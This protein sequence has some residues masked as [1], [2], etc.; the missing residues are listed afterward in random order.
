MSSSALRAPPPKEDSGN[1]PLRSAQPIPLWRGQG[2][3]F[4]TTS[5]YSMRYGFSLMKTSNGSPSSNLISVL[6]PLTVTFNTLP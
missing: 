3:D 6:S 5:F 2:E 4:E 1:M